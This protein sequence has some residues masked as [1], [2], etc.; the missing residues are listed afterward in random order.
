VVLGSETV[1]TRRLLS[2]NVGQPREVDWRGRKVRTSIWKSEVFDRRWV[3]RL[4]VAGD[5]QADLRGHGGEHRAVYVY[6]VSA[7]RHWERELDRD[8]FVN[9]QFG[10]NFTV[11]GLADDQVCIGDRYRIGRALFEVTQP[12]VT[13]HKVGVRMGEPR[14]PALLYAHGRPGFYLRVLEEG[15]VGAGDAIERVSVGPEAM[16]VREV[17]ALLYLPGQTVRRLE[18]ALAIPALP[19]GWRHSF[20]ALLEQAA[21]G[22]S[23]NRGLAPPSSGPPAWEG[24]R[25]F[26]IADVVRESASIA[27]FV[28]EPV[29][30]EP[31]PTFRPGQ[32]LTIRVQPAGAPRALLRSFSLS[33]APDARRYR[34]SIKREPDGVVSAHL[35]NQVAPG[36]V[37]EVGAPRGTFTLEPAGA[38]EPVVLLSAG[39]GATPVLAMLESLSNADSRREVWW[40]HGARSRAEHAFADD[41][42]RHLAA[43]GNARSH[44]RYSRPAASDVP[45]RDYDA[46][47][48]VTLEV[49]QELAVPLTATYFLCGPLDWMRELATGLQVWGIGPERIHTEIFGSEPLEGAERPPHLPPGEPGTGPEVAFT[50][51]GLTVRWDPAFGSLLELAE[52]CDVPAAWSCR[53]GVCHTCECG[54]VDGEVAYLPDPLDPPEDGRALICCS[55]PTSDVAL[56][57]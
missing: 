48:R 57:L 26:R 12:R 4:N 31:L 13:C 42:R 25:P 30:G 46:E 3:S 56:E 16:T 34:L 1:V 29:D 19:E 36:D 33:A 47:G 5:A 11:Q 24:L 6:D 18:R 20:E 43:L 37:I 49:L 44:I 35:H 22:G 50:T 53:T 51:S 38:G 8:D 45:G 21:Q 17:S 23:G 27:S 55:R 41:A 28:L 54:L 7:Y 40:I 2:V 32:F 39:V 10:E 15:E 9:G 52:A 14:M